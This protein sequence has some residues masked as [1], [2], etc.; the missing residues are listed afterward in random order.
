M[1]RN[2]QFS[3]D[4]LKNSPLQYSIKNEFIQASFT[5]RNIK[6]CSK[7]FFLHGQTSKKC[8]QLLSGATRSSGLVE[9]QMVVGTIHKILLLHGN[10]WTGSANSWRRIHRH[11]PGG[12]WAEKTSIKVYEVCNW[13]YGL[14]VNALLRLRGSVTTGRE[15]LYNCER[16]V[17]LIIFHKCKRWMLPYPSSLLIT[18]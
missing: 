16:A 12:T 3:V 1:N 18:R 14:A 5:R 9:V 6:S 15:R 2:N 11:H 10:H 4:Y 8:L 13:S 17:C 7:R